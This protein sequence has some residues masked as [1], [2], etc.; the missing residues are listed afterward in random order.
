M[1]ADTVPDV[2]AVAD[3]DIRIVTDSWPIST[4]TR[5]VDDVI[6]YVIAYVVA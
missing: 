2:H 5:A 6:A 1:V 4:N 3:I